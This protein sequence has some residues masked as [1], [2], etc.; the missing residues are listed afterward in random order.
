MTHDIPP[1]GDSPFTL[2]TWPM[3]NDGSYGAIDEKT[4]I[5]TIH[6]ALDLGVTSFDT[7]P[8]YG[9]GE[10]ERLLGKALAGRRHRAIITTKFGVVPGR[11]DARRATIF[12]QAEESLARLGTDYID[13]YVSH[14]ADKDTPVEESSA[15]LD[16]LVAAGKI[17]RVGVSNQPVA[18]VEQW[19]AA[20]RIDTVQV[21]YNLFDRRMESELLPYCR[22][23]RIAVMAYGPLAHGLLV[24][25]IT[26]ARTYGPRD[27]RTKGFAIGQP[28]FTAENFAINAAVVRRLRDE[29]A[30]PMGITVSQLAVSW[31]LDHPAV[32]TVLIGARTPAELAED[33]RAPVR[34]GA[35]ETALIQEIMAGAAGRVAVFKPYARAHEDWGT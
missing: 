9:A 5:D 31:V 20:R 22:E 28:I 26:D 19:C 10:A 12:H 34:L 14:W 30:R 29:V 7:A 33:V 27:W 3:S 23:R 4:A 6:A 11:R 21:G 8:G 35:G 1:F 16:E 24:D 17:R 15:A 32:T 25:G 2:G 13:Y 18:L